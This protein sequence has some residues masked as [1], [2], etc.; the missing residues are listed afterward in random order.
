MS[1]KNLFQ[2]PRDPGECREWA[3]GPL[4]VINGPAALS[5]WAWK[6]LIT[7]ERNPLRLF[8]VNWNPD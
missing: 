4:Q 1:F 3:R 8:G 5:I 2:P 6:L 7:I